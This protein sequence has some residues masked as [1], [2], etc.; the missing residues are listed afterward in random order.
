MASPQRGRQIQVRLVEIGDFR[1]IIILA[2]SYI[3]ETIQDMDIATTQLM[4]IGLYFQHFVWPFIS[5]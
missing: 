4:L 5:S 2:I 3:L 1:P